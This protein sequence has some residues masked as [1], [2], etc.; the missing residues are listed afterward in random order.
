M[1]DWKK[2]HEKFNKSVANR[3][4]F[5]PPG[6]LQDIK[7]QEKIQKVEG[8]NK[9]EFFYNINEYIPKI[10]NHGQRVG[11]FVIVNQNRNDV[12][13]KVNFVYNNLQFKVNGKWLSGNP[14]QLKEY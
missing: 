1:P 6:E 2:L 5:L 3:Y 10:Q 9:L 4:F 7:G 12:Q 14:Q 13:E 8:L 11:V